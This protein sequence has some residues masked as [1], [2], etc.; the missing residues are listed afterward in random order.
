[1]KWDKPV[2]Y[3]LAF[4]RSF[5]EIYT[6]GALALGILWFCGRLRFD[7]AR[8]WRWIAAH[9]LGCFVFCLSAVVLISWL[10]SG[11]TSVQNGQTLRFSELLPKLAVTCGFWGF[12]KYWIIVLGHLGW[13]NYKQYRERERQAAAMRTELVEARLQ[14]LRMQL[15]PHFLFNTLN[16]VLGLIHENPKA[17]DRMLVLLGDLLRCTLD[18]GQIHEVPLR[19]ELKCLQLYLKIEQMRFG[20]RLSISYEVD[21]DT[22]DAM[23]PQLILQ[24]LVENALRHGLL[25]RDEPGQLRIIA[26]AVQGDLL[27]TVRDDG[28]G[29]PIVPEG[30]IHEGV[31]LCN[32]RSR[33]SHLYGGEHRLMLRNVPAGG[34]E[35][36]IR[37]PYR[38]EEQ[39]CVEPL[40]PLAAE[41]RDG[42]DSTVLLAGAQPR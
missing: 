26:R 16:A 15:N 12:Y 11:Q 21:A 36:L 31:G 23:V 9:L 38:R 33:L 19:E 34:V 8:L 40:S 3:A 35:A 42:T 18:K 25:P 27:L 28:V 39:R 29:F 20:D 4:R 14:A 7:P 17:A 5:E 32:V 30:A 37:I 24:P 10:W 1:L 13:Q 22:Q 41:S 6:Y 2:S